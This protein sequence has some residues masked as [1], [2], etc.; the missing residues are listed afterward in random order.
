MNSHFNVITVADGARLSIG[1]AINI[2]I[3]K[4]TCPAAVFHV[5]IP[6]PGEIGDDLAASIIESQA[7]STYQIDGPQISLDGKPYKIENKITALRQSLVEEAAI[8]VDS[9]VFLNRPL[10]VE[11]LIREAPAAVPEHGF[12]Q[13]PWVDIFKTAN[14]PYRY[15]PVATGNGS[16]GDPWLNAGLVSCRHPRQLGAVWSMMAD[17]VLKLDFVPEKNPYLDQISLIPAIAQLSSGRQI[18]HGSILPDMFNQHV[19]P[20]IDDHSYLRNSY[21]VHHHNRYSLLEKC[22]SK[23]ITWVSGDY[24]ELPE[25]ISRGRIYEKT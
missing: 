17:L 11:F 4:K 16:V 25:L 2:L 13:F 23:L 5:A 9:D 21:V 18:S 3:S 8:F 14:L 20:W 7:A 22:F 10:P 24:P 12:H 19:F 1:V 15:L 6:R